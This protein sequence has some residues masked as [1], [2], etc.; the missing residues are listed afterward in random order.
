MNHVSVYRILYWDYGNVWITLKCV[1]PLTS[2]WVQAASGKEVWLWASS[3]QW[4]DLAESCQQPA[5]PAAAAGAV[6]ALVLNGEC[7]GDMGSIL[8]YPL[9]MKPWFWVS[10]VWKSNGTKLF[11]FYVSSVRWLVRC[12]RNGREKKIGK[13]FWFGGKD[14][15]GFRSAEHGIE[16]ELP[17][18]SLEIW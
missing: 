1:I 18:R 3:L 17:C 6:N 11:Y 15:I 9:Q 8:Q 7:W 16:V 5:L 13:E 2:H 12:W 10:S 4:E 14:E